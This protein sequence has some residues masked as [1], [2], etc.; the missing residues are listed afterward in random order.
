M[1]LLSIQC[2]G[3]QLGNSSSPETH[4]KAF[5]LKINAVRPR[6]A[7]Q[8]CRPCAACR[9]ASPFPLIHCSVPFMQKPS[10]GC[11]WAGL[12]HLNPLQHTLTHTQTQINTQRKHIYKEHTNSFPCMVSVCMSRQCTS[13]GACT[14]C[15]GKRWTYELASH[16]PT[17]MHMIHPCSSKSPLHDWPLTFRP[18]GAVSCSYLWPI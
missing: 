1:R 15:E 2:S 17:H 16:K 9:L 18:T 8:P 14:H 11:A 4:W 3:V 5:L 13:W 12:G 6:P 7:S 10:Y